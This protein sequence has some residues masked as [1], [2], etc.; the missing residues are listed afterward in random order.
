MR[1]AILYTGCLRTIKKTMRYFKQNVLLN[2][3]VDV[4]ACIQNDKGDSNEEWELWIKNE[5]GSHLKSIFWFD[6][7]TQNHWIEQR[8]FMLQFL[9][10]AEGFKNYLKSSGSI[11]EYYQMQ[12]AYMNMVRFERSNNFNYDYIIRVRTDTIFAKPVDFHWLNWAD[13]EVEERIEKIKNKMISLNK[14][15]NEEHIIHYFMSTLLSDDSIDNI[16]NLFME[17]II[18]P[19]NR[20]SLASLNDYIKNGHYILTFRSNLLYIVKRDLFHMIPV[21]GSF[22]GF[23]NHPMSDSCYWWNAETQFR[24]AC[25]NSNLSIF[26][27]STIFDE[28]SVY[29][30]DEK[31][32]F[33][34]NYNIINPYM[35]YCLVRN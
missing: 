12:L 15:L 18:H 25:Y 22:Y 29:E 9:D 32:Y 4:F 17:F 28:K 11:I 2:S 10:I 27:Y 20:P 7:S 21:L 23:Y 19:Y 14:E 31:R 8:N 34:D 30:Y 35:L 6:H 1:V 13:T 33:D 24:G 5:I 16:E 3:D 26:S